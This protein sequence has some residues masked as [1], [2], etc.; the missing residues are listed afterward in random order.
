MKTLFRIAQVAYNVYAAL[1]FLAGLLV[2]FLLA[3]PASLM[4]RIQGGTIIYRLSMAWADV[5]FVLVG[6]RHYNLG[7]L[8][9]KDETFVFVA[10]HSSWLDAATVPKTFRYPIR[11]LAKADTAKLPMFGF[12]YSRAAVLVDRSNPEARLR[13]VAR[14]KAVLRKNISILVFPEGTFNESP[15]LLTHFYDGAFRIAIETGTA[16]KPVLLLDSK[17]RMPL[18]K[19]FSLN[20]GRSR[21][22]FLHEIPIDG[23][24]LDD[25]PSLRT[26]TQQYMLDALRAWQNGEGS[27]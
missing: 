19:Y 17:F 5:W 27:S 9:K 21:A 6:I 13:S 25:V 3:L 1:L 15:E 24:S 7:S 16:L 4:G 11:P 18:G 12:I 10:N 14:L 23:L 26:Q 2:V 8:P 22:F 20:P